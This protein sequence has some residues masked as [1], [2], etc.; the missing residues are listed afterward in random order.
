MKTEKMEC[1]LTL[2]SDILGTIPKNKEIYTKFVA[3]KCVDAGLSEK[4]VDTV[5]D[6]EDKGWT[7]FRTDEHGPFLPSYMI[8]G[9]LKAAAVALKAQSE[10]KNYKS[11]IDN[12]VFVFP[13]RIRLTRDK[14]TVMEPDGAYERPLRAMTMQGPRVSLAKSDSISS[15]VKLKFTIEI[16]GNHEGVNQD[17]IKDLF[18]YGRFSGLGQFRNG[19]FG[20]FTAVIK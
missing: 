6:I 12:L 16:I 5:P 3:T 13:D 8:R 19:G 10:I 17:W 20:R 14:K 18:E 11:K 4:E 7:G 9:F 2:T 1:E 15:G